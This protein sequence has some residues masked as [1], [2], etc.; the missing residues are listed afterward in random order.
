[1]HKRLPTTA[2]LMQDREAWDTEE[3]RGGRSPA[4]TVSYSRANEVI[5][6][7]QAIKGIPAAERQGAPP[8][9]S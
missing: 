5:M 6:H 7:P 9:G 4:M 2:V 3:A 1:M 8:R